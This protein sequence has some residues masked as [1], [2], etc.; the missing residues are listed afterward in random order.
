MEC[1]YL[2]VI[3]TNLGLG[4]CEGDS[5]CS[6]SSIINSWPALQQTDEEQPPSDW[7]AEFLTLCSEVALPVQW[8]GNKHFVKMVFGK[9][10]KIKRRKTG[11]KLTRRIII[12]CKLQITR[13]DYPVLIID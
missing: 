2:L 10:V 8:P 13:R 12:E 4:R 1:S 6:S 3:S 5:C 7:S 11:R 9:L